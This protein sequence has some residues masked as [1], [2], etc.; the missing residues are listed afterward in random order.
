MFGSLIC[1]SKEPGKHLS[2]PVRGVLVELA[3]TGIIRCVN[4]LFSPV[5]ARWECLCEK[6]MYQS[7]EILMLCMHSAGTPGHS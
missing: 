5:V 3:T 1:R 2:P 6:A 4:S 7:V